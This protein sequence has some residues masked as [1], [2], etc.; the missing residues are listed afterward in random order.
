MSNRIPEISDELY[1][2]DDAM[3]A[4][5]GWEHGP[6]QIWDAIGVEKGVELM[7][8]E[9]YKPNNWVNEMLSNGVKNF[10]S[11]KNGAKFYYD[12]PK[13]AES[14]IPGQDAFIILDH[15]R[16]IQ[17]VWNVKRVSNTWDRRRMQCRV[18]IQNEYSGRWRIRSY[19]QRNRYG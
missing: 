6:F 2:I 9:G 15:V 1:R 11:V 3:K 19:Q 4:G 14:K 16:E 8:A 13:K 17:T 18:S 12:I 5:F 10:Y 7:L